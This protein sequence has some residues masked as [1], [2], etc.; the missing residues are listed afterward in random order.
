[1]AG[2]P[3]LNGFLSKEM[4][5][6]ESLLVGDDSGLRFVFPAIA[7][8]AGA[9]SV[10]YSARFIHRVFLG[11]L[12]PDIPRAPHEPTRGMLLPSAVLVVACLLR[13]HLS[14]IHG[15]PGTGDRRAIH[16][17]RTTPICELALWHGVTMPPLMSVRCARGRSGLLHQPRTGEAAR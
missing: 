14:G 5:F 2:V 4:F 8:L 17:R 7:T 16:S 15:R 9:F 13:R 10:A 11:S 6:A 12:P 1:M 3:L